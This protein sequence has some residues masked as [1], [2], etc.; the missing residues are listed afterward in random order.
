MTTVPPLIARQLLDSASGALSSPGN[1]AIRI[2]QSKDGSPDERNGI[3][4]VGAFAVALVPLCAGDDRETE[5]VVRCQ[6][7]GSLEG[8]AMKNGL[9][10]GALNSG[11]LLE[12]LFGLQP[13]PM[14]RNVQI[15]SPSML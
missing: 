9:F 7:R 3:C 4:F 2:V 11:R 14:Q 12:P 15:G 1:G 6:S 13:P 8:E 5:G 10:T